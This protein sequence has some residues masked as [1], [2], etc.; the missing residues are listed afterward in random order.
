MT[1]MERLLKTA[2]LDMQKET[3]TTLQA[4][5]T[6]CDGLEQRMAALEAARRQSLKELREELQEVQARQTALTRHLQ[7]LSGIY[8]SLAPLLKRLNAAVSRQP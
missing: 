6:R 4:Q 8:A 2:L 7:R 3:A 1:E 5:S